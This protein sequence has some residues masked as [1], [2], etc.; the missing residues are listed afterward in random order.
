MPIDPNS[1]F[2]PNHCR[3][4]LTALLI[5]RSPSN[6]VCGSD[7]VEACSWRH[8]PV[9]GITEPPHQEWGLLSIFSVPS[10]SRF[11]SSIKTLVTSIF[12][13]CHRSWQLISVIMMI[14]IQAAK[15]IYAQCIV[16]I[17]HHFPCIV[18]IFPKLSRNTETKMS[19]FWRNFN[20]W[21]HWKLSFWQLPVQPV[22]K[23][24]SKWRHFRFSDKV[25]V[26]FWYNYDNDNWYYC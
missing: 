2:R 6:R 3:P 14:V 7:R 19:S 23:I 15:N 12:D 26:A 18:E 1:T 11:F 21:L 4:W 16:N 24:S 25:F 22:M 13:R 20:H 9:L 8:V 5:E 17:Q 10:Y